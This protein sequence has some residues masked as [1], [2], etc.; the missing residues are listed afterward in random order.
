MNEIAAQARH[1]ERTGKNIWLAVLAL[2]RRLILKDH[3][4]VHG[5]AFYN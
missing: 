1:F 4:D 3:N 2:L 5:T